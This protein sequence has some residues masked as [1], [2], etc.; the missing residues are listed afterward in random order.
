MDMKIFD[1]IAIVACIIGYGL[2]IYFKVRGDLVGSLAELIAAAET[3]GLANSEKMAQVVT[4]LAEMIPAPLRG[5]VTESVLRKLAQG[6]FDWMRA[7]ANNY[8]EAKKEKDLEEQQKKLY[9][10]NAKT[11]AAIVAELMKLTRNAL[12]EKAAAE[13][14]IEMEPTASKE[15][16]IKA[17]VYAALTKA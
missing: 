2:M 3:S 4:R 8:I 9:E 12:L 6:I 16:V 1:I 15:D 11:T 14:D 7:Y 5:F 10:K 13:Y 17:I